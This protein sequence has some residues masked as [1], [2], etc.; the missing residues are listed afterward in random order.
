M[1]HYHGGPITPR[2]V[3]IQALKT[4]HACVS[5]ATPQDVELVAEVCQSF[6]FDNGAYP[7]YTSGRGDVDFGAFRDWVLQWHRHPGF[8]WCLIPDKIDGD[9]AEN[10]VLI[11]RWDLPQSVSVPVFHL[12]ESTDRLRRLVRDWPRVALG[13]SGEFWCIGTSKWWARMHEIMMVACDEQ[14]RPMTK[15]HGLRMLDPTI[16]SHLP[17]A[18]ADSTNVARNVGIDVRWHGPYVPPSKETRALV[19]IDRIES[20]ASSARYAATMGTQMTMNWELFG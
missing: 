2:S 6:I 8:D 15:L 9:A 18:S 20:H 14:G 4:R 7:L 13:S 3:A 11:D 1:I 10:D 17:L 5:F 19:M 12:H 16:F